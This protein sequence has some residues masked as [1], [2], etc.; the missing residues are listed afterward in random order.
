MQDVV[1]SGPYIPH[2]KD[3]PFFST[4]DQSILFSGEV[5]SESY[6]PN[7]FEKLVGIRA[8][9]AN[10]KPSDWWSVPVGGGEITRLTHLQTARLYGS[11][12]PDKKHIVSYGGEEIFVMKPDGSELT[13]LFSGL[14]LFHGTVSWIP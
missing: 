5:P 14:N 9:K 4:D 13:I 1:L 11:F 12:S 10:G 7:W 6:R 8:A 2:D 3:A